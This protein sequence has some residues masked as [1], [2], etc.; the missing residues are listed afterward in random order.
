[1]NKLCYFLAFDLGATSG[2]SILATLQEGKICI[3]ELTRFPNRMLRINQQYYWNIYALF[4]ELENALCAV[5]QRNIELSAIGID[6]WGVDFVYLAADG[7]MIGLP[8]AYR[9]PY[10]ANEILEQYFTQISREKIYKTTG[11]QIMNINSLFQLYAAKNE[12]SFAF[13]SADSILFMPDAL[14]YLLTNK[15]V[16]EYSIASTSQLLNV[17]NRKFEEELFEPFGKKTS[18]IPELVMP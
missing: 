6:T 11:I 10:T 15:K 17:W 3:E 8:R 7:T 16:C 5:V 18:I 2:R 9:D 4:E 12:N 13:K 14:I 1:M